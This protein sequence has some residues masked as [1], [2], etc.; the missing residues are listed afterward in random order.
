M[1][2]SAAS[3]LLLLS[4]LALVSI[5]KT[6]DRAPHGISHEN[7]MAFSPSAY[8]FF[9]PKTQNPDPKNSPLLMAAEV[10]KALETKVIPRQKS[11]HRMGAGGV[12]AI[13]LGL[14]FVV[15]SAMG[16]FYVLNTRRANAMASRP[17][18]VQPDA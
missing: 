17:D 8:E 1:S 14:A 11:G 2:P 18:T 15:L 5:A 6:Q 13:V 12:A 9:H 3:F 10:D 4:S 7:P 16:V